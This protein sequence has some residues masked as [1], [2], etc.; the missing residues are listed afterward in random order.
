MHGGGLEPLPGLTRGDPRF[1]D[2]LP[3]E[4]RPCAPVPL[5]VGGRDDLVASCAPVVGARGKGGGRRDWRVRWEDRVC[6]ALVALCARA[7]MQSFG[8]AWEVGCEVGW[9]VRMA[10]P[11]G[12]G[13]KYPLIHIK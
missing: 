10:M 4:R 11:L 2:P 5:A 1:E 7:D 12:T 9:I 6:G 3:R 13:D 8:G